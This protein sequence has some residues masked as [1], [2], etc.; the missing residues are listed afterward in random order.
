MKN[1]AQNT[2]FYLLHYN[3]IVDGDITISELQ[4]T[5]FSVWQDGKQLRGQVWQLFTATKPPKLYAKGNLY[6][7]GNG[8]PAGTYRVPLGADVDD[9]GRAADLRRDDD[10]RRA[11]LHDD[12]DPLRRHVDVTN[13]DSAFDAGGA[14]VNRRERR[15]LAQAGPGLPCP[16]RRWPGHVLSVV[17]ASLP[18]CLLTVHCSAP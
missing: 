6:S 12:E 4:S 1:I 16:R 11:V 14:L 17:W 3:Q 9:S 5:K 18:L 8:L 7:F 10:A 15:R 13:R 2:P